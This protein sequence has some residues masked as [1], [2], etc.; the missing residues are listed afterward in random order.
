MGPIGL[1]YSYIPGLIISDLSNTSTASGLIKRVW[2]EVKV[3]TFDI[4]RVCKFHSIFAFKITLVIILINGGYFKAYP[5]VQRL[6]CTRTINTCR[7]LKTVVGT[8]KNR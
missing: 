6:Y 4:F 2:M 3:F 8:V 1:K 5:L 7:V